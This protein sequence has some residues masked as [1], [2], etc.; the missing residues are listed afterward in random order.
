MEKDIE[1]LLDGFVVPEMEYVK[2]K[3]KAVAQDV[4]E[5]VLPKTKAE[6]YKEAKGRLEQKTVPVSPSYVGGKKLKKIKKPT[7]DET[8]AT[9]ALDDGKSAGGS[10][11][12]E[13]LKKR[14]GSLRK[15][16]EE[17]KWVGSADELIPFAW[18][19][20]LDRKLEKPSKVYRASVVGEKS[21]RALWLPVPHNK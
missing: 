4:P 10:T 13:I 20:P 21:R 12:F 14:I 2:S 19:F 17:P 8:V 5:I 9:V 15:I 7:I 3:S 16:V 18:R 1:K 11:T 6:M